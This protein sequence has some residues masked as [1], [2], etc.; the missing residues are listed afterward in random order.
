MAASTK[1]KVI[2]DYDKLPKEVQNQILS[3]YP[4]GFMDKLVQYPSKNGTMVSALPFETEDMFYLV[5]VNTE[6]VRVV[7]DEAYYDDVMKDDALD[8][9]KIDDMVNEP[10]VE[11]EFD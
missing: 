7:Y 5:R 8:V 11:D 4:Q 6:Q 2:K 9:E 1:P 10:S 3:T